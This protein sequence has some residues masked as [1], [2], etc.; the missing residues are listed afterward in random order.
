MTFNTEH[1]ALEQ[2]LIDHI[3]KYGPVSFEAFM[4]A[5]L[6][7]SKHGYYTN[8]RYLTETSPIGT[9][10]DFF[11]SPTSHPAFGALLS[12][13]LEQMW[14]NLG[15]P[16]VFNVVEMGAGEGVLCS[17]ILEYVQRELPDFAKAIN[18][19]ATDRAPSRDSKTVFDSSMLPNGVSGCVLSN[20]LLDAM[21]VHRF[22][23]LNGELLEI[24][25]DYKDGEFVESY[26]DTSNPEIN[27][28]VDPF[29]GILP[30]GYR[31][32]VNLH[33][34]YWADSVAAVLERGYAITIDYGF[35]RSEL[36]K[37]TRI[38]GSLRCYFQ[39]TL[40]QNPLF[41][42][43]RQ[44]ITS[45][46][47]FTAVD[48]CLTVM[49]F[50]R[51]GKPSQQEFLI[52]LGIEDFLKEIKIKETHKEISRIESQENLAGVGSLINPK[53]LGSFSVAVHSRGLG[54]EP[55]PSLSGIDRGGY[56]T[57]GHSA[58]LLSSSTARHARLL[59][60][61]NPFSISQSDFSVIPAWEEIFSDEI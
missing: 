10:G 59:R 51:I 33:I 46:V 48:H 43:G 23:V 41:R 44:D 21:P 42:I 27:A 32:E 37:S 56:L 58:P 18:Y 26:G 20:E 13:Q 38:D 30:E 50:Q 35:D 39:H 36:Y 5:A 53:G 3:L 34:G 4:D 7:D 1:G 61:S 24:Y 49:G 6:Y 40:S 12:L 2:R 8:Q 60:S 52:N 14:L 9:G 57:E 55:F 17:D 54:V 11:T 25:V 45:H 22:I 28:R 19:I 47:D 29:L 15:A 16:D 31:G